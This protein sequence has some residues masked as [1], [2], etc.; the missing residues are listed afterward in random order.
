[1]ENSIQTVEDFLCN[2]PTF[3]LSTVDEDGR[4][5]CR[6]IGYHELEDGRIYFGVGTFK[7]VYRQMEKNPYV[8]ICACD[9][10][11]F[12]RYFGRAVFEEDYSR[13]QRVLDEKPGLKKVYEANGHKLGVFHLEEATAELHAMSKL[14]SSFGV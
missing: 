6:P 8:E 9:G 5:K 1:M 4:P 12:L 7:D 3:F 11:K 14:V 10:G 13:A 2:T